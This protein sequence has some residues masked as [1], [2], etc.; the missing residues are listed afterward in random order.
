MWRNLLI[1]DCHNSQRIISGYYA[2]VYLFSN[3]YHL[4]GIGYKSLISISYTPKEIIKMANL[5]YNFY[6]PDNRLVSSNYLVE[7]VE[8]NLHCFDEYVLN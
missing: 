3:L 2:V 7:I 4:T 1:K 8:N 6:T 5:K